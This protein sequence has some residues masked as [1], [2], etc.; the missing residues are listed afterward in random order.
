ML[1]Q[2]E[3][4][5][6]MRQNRQSSL[7]SH[8]LKRHKI[9]GLL[10]L[11]FKCCCFREIFSKRRSSIDIVQWDFKMINLWKI[12]A[13]ILN[14]VS[15]TIVQ[16]ILE[17]SFLKYLM[18]YYGLCKERQNKG[19][20]LLKKKKKRYLPYWLRAMILLNCLLVSAPLPNKEKSC[21]SAW[22]ATE[23]DVGDSMRLLEFHWTWINHEIE[24][25]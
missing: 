4:L 6:Q 24:T 16:S 1:K 18:F 10:K 25:S 20:L 8:Q 5:Y 17:A 3:V 21:K 23:V 12:S 2:M 15:A 13:L 22:A 14:M 11:L 19:G 9:Y 7:C